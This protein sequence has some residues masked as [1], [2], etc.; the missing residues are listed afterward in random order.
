MSNDLG[1]LKS[2]RADIKR[3]YGYAQ[4]LEKEQISEEALGRLCR[5]Y[6]DFGNEI[7]IRFGRSFSAA[8]K[9]ATAATS[10]LSPVKA[11]AKELKIKAWNF[12][13]EETL[14]KEIS[15]VEGN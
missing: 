15:E 1:L 7:H 11:K 4:I 8:K 13:S 9:T 5:E 10:E 3:G 14:A 6:P 2:V 12:K